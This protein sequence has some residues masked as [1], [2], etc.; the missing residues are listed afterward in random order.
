MR[1]RNLLDLFLSRSVC[2]RIQHGK[3]L[4]SDQNFWN[5]LGILHQQHTNLLLLS[6]FVQPPKKDTKKDTKA[7]A[8]KKE[9]G[10][11]KAK[12]K[13]SIH[14][15]TDKCKILNVPFVSILCPAEVVQGKGPW[16]VEQLG[17]FR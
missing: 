7:P 12:K 13:A 6:F 1:A 16:Q 14:F 11:G 9:G 17:P 4:V 2:A 3:Q 10:G 8:K 5:L 15:L